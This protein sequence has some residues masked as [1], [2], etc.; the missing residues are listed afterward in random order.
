[1]FTFYRR[2]KVTLNHVKFD[3]S[4]Q[5]ETDFQE[6]QDFKP[7]MNVAQNGFVKIAFHVIFC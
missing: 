3:Q 6:M 7:L 1:M 2:E 4:G 5:T